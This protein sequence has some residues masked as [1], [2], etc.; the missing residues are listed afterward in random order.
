MSL[1]NT[2]AQ[3]RPRGVQVNAL[4]GKLTAS[5]NVSKEKRLVNYFLA[6]GSA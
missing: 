6:I 1:C 3:G 4:A 2:N 5:T